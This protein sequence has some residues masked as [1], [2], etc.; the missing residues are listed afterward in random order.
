MIFALAATLALAA[1][2][3]GFATDRETLSS[4]MRQSCQFQ[5]ARDQGGE[6]ADYAAFCSCLDAELAGQSGDTMYR[7]MALGS[8]GAIGEDA[9]V[10]DPAAA[11]AEAQRLVDTAPEEERAAL[12]LLLQSSLGTCMPAMPE[13]AVSA[14]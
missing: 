8:Q 7:V 10:D 14:E 13:Q 3:G 4:Y 6:P 2:H 9:L 11:L 5:Q 12:P 1:Q